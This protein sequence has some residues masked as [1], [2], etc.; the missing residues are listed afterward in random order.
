MFKQRVTNSN[1]VTLKAEGTVKKK[2][3][4]LSSEARHESWDYQKK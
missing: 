2:C 4:E 3:Q 1:I